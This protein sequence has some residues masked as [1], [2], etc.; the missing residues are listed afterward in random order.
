[1][2]ASSSSWRRNPASKQNDLCASIPSTPRSSSN[3]SGGG[4]GGDGSGYGH[5][6][7]ERA[8]ARN[9][10]AAATARYVRGGSHESP[11]APAAPITV[12]VSRGRQVAVPFP[13]GRGAPATTASISAA[14]GIGGGP[15]GAGGENR[16][17]SSGR[18]QSAP[19]GNRPI[20]YGR[21]R[22]AGEQRSSG[23]QDQGRRGGGEWFDPP[24]VASERGRRSAV[25]A[26][27]PASSAARP[28]LAQT[29]ARSSGSAGV[30]LGELPPR[31]GGGVIHADQGNGGLEGE[32]GAGAAGAEI[33][34]DV[35][36]KLDFHA[37]FD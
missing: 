31:F 3:S 18:R 23:N 7:A 25:S 22:G 33:R 16:E 20:G 11:A 28:R 2:G 10:G 26:A 29:G 34:E 21:P 1:M 24:T 15:S 30:P 35:A 32:G 5:T 19:V 17:S 27:D 4:G 37:V 12:T 6:S 36:K 14:G 13:A 8:R 9:G